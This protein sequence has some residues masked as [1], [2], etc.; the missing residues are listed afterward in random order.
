MDHCDNVTDQGLGF[1]RSL[2]EIIF[3]GMLV[4]FILFLV[5]NA[6]EYSLKKKKKQYSDSQITIG[7]QHQRAYF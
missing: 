5:G 3:K 1:G 4:F 2:K 7:S 6:M